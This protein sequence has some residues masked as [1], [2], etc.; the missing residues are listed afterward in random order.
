MRLLVPTAVRVETGW[1]RR[2]PGS[3]AINHVRAD[4]IPL[5]RATAD[6][7]AALRRALTISV[8]DAHL[9][10]AVEQATR[11]VAVL[12]SNVGD[13]RRITAHLDVPVTVIAT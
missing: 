11:P 2:D 12:T 5:D 7:A 3:A 4:D 9:G 6:R 8:A 13:V 1:D 10:V